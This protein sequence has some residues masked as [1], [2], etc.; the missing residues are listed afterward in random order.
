LIP[1]PIATPQVFALF[2]LTAVIFFL[3]L[4]FPAILELKKP[5]DAG[6]RRI[7]EADGKEILGFSF[8]FAVYF[9]EKSRC[10]PLSLE[11]IESQEF[12]TPRKGFLSIPLPDMEF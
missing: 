1:I 11:D 6:P 10:V 2:A 3:V 4:F 7:L 9:R 8:L 12:E 5:K